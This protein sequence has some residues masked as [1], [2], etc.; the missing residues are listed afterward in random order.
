V[1]SENVTGDP[2]QRPD[3]QT[4]SAESIGAVSAGP[5]AARLAAIRRYEIL[6]A[7]AD[8]TFDDIAQVAA[9]VFAAPI[10]AVS[11][12]DTDRVFLAASRGLDGVRQLGVE[13]GLCVSAMLADSPYVV[14]DAAA[15]PRTLDHPLVRGQLGIRF[16]AATAIITADGHR[17]GTVNVMDYHSRQVSDRQTTVLSTLARIIARHL[18]LRLAAL[19]DV[20]VERQLRREADRRD[21]ASTKLVVQLREAAAAHASVDRPPTCELG[22]QTAPC[23]QPAELKILDGWGVAAWG[24]LP[25]VEET[26]TLLPSVYLAD[27]DFAGLADYLNRN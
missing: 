20:R 23:I 4:S 13:P 22:G 5:E 25:H 18:D 15:D 26:I 2:G 1:S 12:V 7:P 6:D 16:Y 14:N 17:L 10:A 27:R 3:T 11:I 21:A 19:S 8:G 24:C 9:V